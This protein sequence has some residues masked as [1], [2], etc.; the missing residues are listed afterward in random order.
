MKADAV[1]GD[2]AGGRTGIWCPCPTTTSP[3]GI[4]VTGVVKTDYFQIDN[5]VG[6][7]THLDRV[8]IDSYH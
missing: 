8:Y 7:H 1:V 4:S 3:S 6:T 5:E 2:D